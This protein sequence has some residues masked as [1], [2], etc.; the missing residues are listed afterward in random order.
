MTASVP[1]NEP[2]QLRIGDTW[3]WN[4][5]D[6]ADYPAPT[7]TLK[8]ALK[9][10]AS[11]IEITAAADGSAFA[12]TVAK[13]T[14][15]GYT[16]GRYRWVAYVGDGTTQTEVDTGWV[17]VL[18][19]YSAAS[20]VALDDRTH[21]RKALDAIEAVIETRATMDQQEY[22]IGSRSLKRMDPK[23]LLS[24]R[25]YYRAQVFAEE[26]GER[27]RNGYGAGRLVAKL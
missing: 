6:L 7:W 18:P 23:E 22:T 21:A 27:R 17:D 12:V 1:T 10:A 14:T 3:R 9:N 11:H 25:D 5:Q 8:Y 26:N 15:A 20:Q 13:A 24:W 19:S 4:R 2:L 16:A